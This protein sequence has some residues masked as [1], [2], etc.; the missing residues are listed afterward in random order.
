MALVAAAPHVAYT[1]FKVLKENVSQFEEEDLGTR[2][3]GSMIATGI[4]TGHDVS[5]YVGTLSKAAK[6]TWYCCNM[7]DR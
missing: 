6:E 7:R 1:A 4:H 2:A 5:M 3:A